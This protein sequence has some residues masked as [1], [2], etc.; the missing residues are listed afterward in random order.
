M[1]VDNKEDIKRNDKV[2]VTGQSANDLGHSSLTG[3]VFLNNDATNTFSIHCDQTDEI[4]LI[5]WNECS[6]EKE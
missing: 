2:V 6:V 4:E 3:R 1:K 5:W